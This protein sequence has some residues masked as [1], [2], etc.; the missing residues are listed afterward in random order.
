MFY[1]VYVSTLH[2]RPGTYREV[3]SRIEHMVSARQAI[4][5]SVG[6]YCALILVR[7]F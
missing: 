1:L 2:L 4:R 7:W 3:T 5:L 6:H